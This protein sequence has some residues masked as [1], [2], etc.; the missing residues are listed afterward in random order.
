MEDYFLS[1][2][3]WAILG[4]FLSFWE[5]ERPKLVPQAACFGLKVAIKVGFLTAKEIKIARN[6]RHES[7]KRRF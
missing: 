5:H 7:P 6:A 2:I 3:N 4:G 1:S